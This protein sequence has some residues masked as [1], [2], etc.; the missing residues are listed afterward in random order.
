MNQDLEYTI[1]GKR[2]PKFKSEGE[3]RI[4]NFLEDN[5]IRY[6]YEPGL[7]VN[8][9]G[10]RPR[11]WYPDFYLPE[12]ASYIEYFGLV[13]RQSYD[14]GIKRKLAGYSKMGMDVIPIYPWTFAD[15]WQRYIMKELE[16]TSIRRYR[17]LMNKP[18]W[19]QPKPATYQ[20]ANPARFGY[21]RGL[22]KHY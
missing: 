20:H 8:S 19:S 10:D 18:Y 13:G 16:H 7:L 3:R 22:N 1:E 12:F 11:I 2:P 6:Q 17:K 9:D 14:R 21:N 5:S 15:N 4:A